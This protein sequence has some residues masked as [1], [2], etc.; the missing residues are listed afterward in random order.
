MENFCCPGL[1][2]ELVKL[3]LTSYECKGSEL[4]KL[5]IFVIYCILWGR[6]EA[7]TGFRWGNL[8]GKR[9]LGRPRH[10]W[11]DNIKID[12]HLHEVGCGGID[13]IELAQD[14]DLWWALVNVEMNLRVP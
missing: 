7:Y 9:P 3:Q 12:L 11:E 5:I 4:M 8:R 1:D 13:W 14:R 10:R 6:G 2:I